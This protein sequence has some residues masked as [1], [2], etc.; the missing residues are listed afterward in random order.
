MVKQGLFPR[1]AE[2]LI[3]SMQRTQ[4]SQEGKKKAINFKY[5]LH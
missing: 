5:K 3:D 1:I 4:V 2:I